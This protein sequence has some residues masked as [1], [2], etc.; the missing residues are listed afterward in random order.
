MLHFCGQLDRR[1]DT[2]LQSWPRSGSRHLAWYPAC[3]LTGI[4]WSVTATCATANLPHIPQPAVLLVQLLCIAYGRFKRTGIACIGRQNVCKK[5]E[6]KIMHLLF[7]FFLFA[8]AFICTTFFVCLKRPLFATFIAVARC[9]GRRGADP[10]VRT[11][12][13]QTCLHFHKAR[14]PVVRLLLPYLSVAD[15][16]AQV[17]V[18]A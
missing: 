2:V 14:P 18:T 12:S 5:A 9:R 16:N 3:S 7:V 13:G 10:K 8:F 4:C 17:C 15:V 6:K 11:A 1:Y